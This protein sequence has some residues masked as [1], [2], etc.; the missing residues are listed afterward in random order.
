MQQQEN[1]EKQLKHLGKLYSVTG[2]EKKKNYQNL[3]ETKQT[4]S[5]PPTPTPRKIPWII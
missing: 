4:A 2:F 3:Q 5:L 1:K